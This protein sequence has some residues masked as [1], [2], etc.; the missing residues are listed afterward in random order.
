MD[1]NP[2][3]PPFPAVSTE[4]LTALDKLFPNKEAVPTDTLEGIMYVGGQRHVIRLLRQRHAEQVGR[5]VP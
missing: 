5:V 3:T 2:S 4:L 1:N